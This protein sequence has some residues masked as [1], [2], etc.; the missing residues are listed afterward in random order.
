MEMDKLLSMIGLCKK[1]GR[2][3]Q[4]YE[5]VV[6]SVTNGDVPLVLTTEDLSPRSLRKLLQAIEPT[7]TTHRVIPVTMDTVAGRLGRR[8]GILGIADQGFAD[9]I[10][11]LIAVKEDVL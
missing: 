4:G 3:E 6:E 8:V 7:T 9:A 10:E 2:L 5:V 11:K 1:A